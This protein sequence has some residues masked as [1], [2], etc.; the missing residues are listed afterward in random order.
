[1]GNVALHFVANQGQWTDDVAYSARSEGATVYRTDEGIV[2]GFAEGKVGLTFS[3][4]RRVKPEARGLLPGVVNYFVGH[5]AVRW[6]AGV[7]TFQEVVYSE[8]Y[9]GID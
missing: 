5:D 2:F 1:M 9:P 7:P 6:Q 3:D 8:V 4:Q